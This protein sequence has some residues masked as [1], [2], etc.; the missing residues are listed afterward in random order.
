MAEFLPLD[1][2]EA[3]LADL[4]R[5]ADDK[6]IEALHLAQSQGINTYDIGYALQHV[7]LPGS[8]QPEMNTAEKREER[9]GALR[10]QRWNAHQA[11]VRRL[12]MLMEIDRI[13]VPPAWANE[14]LTYAV[15]RP[16]HVDPNYHAAF[17]KPEHR[18]LRDDYKRRLRML[19]FT[20]RVCREEEDAV[21]VLCPAQ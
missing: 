17:D 9:L 20:D 16:E 18:L 13:P 8:L 3:K 11:A 10:E 6:L 14:L 5:S 15:I 7:G 12:K 4:W 19:C 1:I 21:L 2:V